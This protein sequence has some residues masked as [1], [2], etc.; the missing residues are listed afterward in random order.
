MDQWIVTQQYMKHHC[1]AWFQITHCNQSFKELTF[2]Q[3]WDCF[4]EE[5][6]QISGKVIKILLPFPTTYLLEVQLPS[7]ISAKTAYQNR[8]NKEA[9]PE[10]LGSHFCETRQ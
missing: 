8:F 7:N 10:W 9:I 6:L 5:I 4:K 3:F 2:I 1:S